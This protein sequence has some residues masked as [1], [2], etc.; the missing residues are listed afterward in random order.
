VPLPAQ[1]S[2]LDAAL[3][4]LELGNL[5]EAHY[6]LEQ[7]PHSERI[8]PEVL[9]YAVAFIARL[10]KGEYLSILAESCYKARPEEPQFVVDWAWA[11]FKQGCQE[12]AAVILLHKEREVSTERGPGLPPGGCLASL[13]RLAESREW[14]A[15]AFERAKEPEKLKLRALDNPALSKLWSESGGMNG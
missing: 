12:Q 9:N 2:S 13:D 5:V 10:R 4:W 11:E 6:E 3:G 8:R 14:L 7:L 15:K 1:S